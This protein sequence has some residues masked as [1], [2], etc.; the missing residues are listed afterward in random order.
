M[1][2]EDIRELSI[3]DIDHVNGDEV[4]FGGNEESVYIYHYLNGEFVKVYD[5][6]YWSSGGPRVK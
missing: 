2:D 5:C 3:G 4:V 1:I 6:V